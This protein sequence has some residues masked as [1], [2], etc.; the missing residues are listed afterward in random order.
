MKNITTYFKYPLLSSIMHFCTF[1]SSSL[2][3][4]IEIGNKKINFKQNHFPYYSI[5]EAIN[6]QIKLVK[7]KGEFLG[8]INIYKKISIISLIVSMTFL[9]LTIINQQDNYFKYICLIIASFTLILSFPLIL[10]FKFDKEETEE[11]FSKYEDY[12]KNK[13]KEKEDKPATSQQSKIKPIAFEAS[14][15]ALL[16]T[17]LK[18]HKIIDCNSDKEYA[19]Y[20][21]KVFL[22]QTLKHY[23]W[24]S[25]SNIISN[26][27]SSAGLSKTFQQYFVNSIYISD[28]KK[29]VKLSTNTSKT[30]ETIYQ[31]LI[32]SPFSFKIKNNRQ[33]ELF[34]MIFAHNIIEEKKEYLIFSNSDLLLLEKLKKE[35]FRKW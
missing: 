1:Y 7:R 25:I 35:Y 13:L 2:N 11:R 9:A 3:S 23:K 15:N 14:Q 21:S 22:K 5:E 20:S 6:S 17:I 32:N 18:D 8:T 28:I 16:Y 19:E 10:I 34:I 12:L 27:N 4:L 26:K 33:L 30:A 24:T 29:R 31:H